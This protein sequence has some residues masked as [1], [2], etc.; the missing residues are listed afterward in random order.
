MYYWPEDDPLRSKRVARLNIQQLVVVLTAVYLLYQTQRDE[1]RKKHNFSLRPMNVI[2]HDNV[3]RFSTRPV[4]RETVPFL[5]KC[6]GAPRNFLGRQIVTLFDLG[7]SRSHHCSN[8]ICP[9]PTPM[10]SEFSVCYLCFLTYVVE[11]DWA[12]PWQCWRC[13]EAVACKW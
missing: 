4:F 13:C 11:I 2:F 1:K 10:V 9:Y 12:F 6:P 7:I 3:R 8:A 5:K